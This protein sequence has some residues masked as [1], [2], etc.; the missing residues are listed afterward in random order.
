MTV[1]L[2]RPRLSARTCP[3]DGPIPGGIT[4]VFR[5]ARIGILRVTLPGQKPDLQQVRAAFG[6]VAAARAPQRTASST[7]T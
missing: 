7:E 5:E 4:A 1:S 2:R 3:G 6:P